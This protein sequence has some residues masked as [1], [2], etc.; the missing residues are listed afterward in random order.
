M[1]PQSLGLPL[2]S[3]KRLSQKI[4][5]LAVDHL[6]DGSMKNVANYV[7]RCELQNT[8]NTGTLNAHGRLVL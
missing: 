8:Q 7:K 2:T 1:P 5:L 3:L 6:A 4:Q